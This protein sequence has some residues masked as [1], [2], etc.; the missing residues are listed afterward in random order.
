M[1]PHADE[2]P[3]AQNGEANARNVPREGDY[4]QPEVLPTGGNLNRWSH[5]LT[6]GHDFP[7]AQ[8][9][10]T[11]SLFHLFLPLWG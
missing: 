4:L 9:S 11:S 7:G 10:S 1:A 3:A 5:V 8:V 6:R 2:A